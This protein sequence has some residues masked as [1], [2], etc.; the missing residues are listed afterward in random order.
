VYVALGDLQDAVMKCDR[1]SDLLAQFDP[2]R[3][4]RPP[5][6]DDPPVGTETGAP[7]G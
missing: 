6:L 5:L 7:D 3:H 2:D 1:L 4:R